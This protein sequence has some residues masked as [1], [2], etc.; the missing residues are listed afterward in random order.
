MALNIKNAR[1]ERLAAD[2]ARLAS[3]TKTEAIGRALEERKARLVSLGGRRTRQAEFIAFLQREVWPTIPRKYR[4]RR[5]TR[6]EKDA[7]LGYGP[8]GV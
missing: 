2:V 6:K 3:E 1:V 4:R 5:L 8:E 7:V